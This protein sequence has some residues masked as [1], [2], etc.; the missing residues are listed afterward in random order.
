MSKQLRKHQRGITLMGL[1]FV[2]GVIGFI[3][4]IA[5]QAIPSV[6]EYLAIKKNLKT[7]VGRNFATVTEI[8]TQFDGYKHL[9]DIKSISAKDLVITKTNSKTIISFEYNKEIAVVEPVYVLIKYKG[10]TA[11]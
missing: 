1:I 5:M 8:K 7:I 3:G 2:G 4:L 10:S 6:S 11:D 9:D